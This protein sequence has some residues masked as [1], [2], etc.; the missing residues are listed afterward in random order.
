MNPFDALPTETVGNLMLVAMVGIVLGL[1]WF[2]LDC[3]RGKGGDD[4]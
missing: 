1:L 4:R 3:H 2:L